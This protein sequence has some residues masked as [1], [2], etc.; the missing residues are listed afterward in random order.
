MARHVRM[1][2]PMA[3][4]HFGESRFSHGV[5]LEDGAPSAASPTRLQLARLQA[6]SGACREFAQAFLNA[7]L[8]GA[9][10][11]KD[12]KKIRADFLVWAGRRP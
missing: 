9:H 7:A 3:N 2:I 8:I 4:F 5:Y 6:M 1:R 10:V 12:R 11:N